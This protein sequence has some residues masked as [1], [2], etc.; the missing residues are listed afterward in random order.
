MAMRKVGRG[1]ILVFVN[2]GVLLGLALGYRNYNVDKYSLL[3]I[4]LVSLLVFNGMVFAIRVS[5]PDL[6]ATRL[7]RMNKWVVWPILVLAG[8]I[9]LWELLGSKW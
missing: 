6:P 7:K 9:L 8:L 5:E 1:L 2:L 4:G 3:G